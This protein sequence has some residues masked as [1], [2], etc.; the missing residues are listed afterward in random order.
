MILSDKILFQFNQN[1]VAI[2]DPPRAG[3]NKKVIGVLRYNELIESLVYISCDSSNDNAQGNI[4][5]LCRDTSN[6]LPGKPYRFVQNRQ[7]SLKISQILF[8]ES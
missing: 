5:D 8:L 2:V 1:T 4:V 3:L 7:F 6:S